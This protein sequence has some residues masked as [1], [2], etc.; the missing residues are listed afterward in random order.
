M[1]LSNSTFFEKLVREQSEKTVITFDT[2]THYLQSDWDKVSRSFSD[3]L[4]YAV[5]QE[6]A[7]HVIGSVHSLQ[8]LIHQLKN[9]GVL[10]QYSDEVKNI[11][12]LHPVLEDHCAAEDQVTSLIQI[13]DASPLCTLS[14]LIDAEHAR[15]TFNRWDRTEIYYRMLV[16]AEGDLFTNQQL[17]SLDQN[18][19]SVNFF[20]HIPAVHH[21]FSG[22]QN[23]DSLK[24]I[25][26]TPGDA[27]QI[28][29]SFHRDRFAP[30]ERTDI[31]L[32][33]LEL[34]EPYPD[35]I[36]ILISSLAAQLSARKSLYL[37]FG[38]MSDYYYL[39]HT[40]S[41]QSVLP[42]SWED[43][44]FLPANSQ[45][46]PDISDYFLKLLNHVESGRY[47][48]ILASLPTKFSKSETGTIAEKMDQA[49][50]DLR[51]LT[52]ESECISLFCTPS[53]ARK[54]LSVYQRT[55]ETM[56]KFPEGTTN[57]LFTNISRRLNS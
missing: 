56:Q 39:T 17:T 16:H 53:T 5:Y 31:E 35:D 44:V 29:R 30:F 26:D 34:F 55:G 10:S 33:S 32:K 23:G 57:E 19:K 11:L 28:Y 14:S 49:F 4:D 27:E 6:K 7:L 51:K 25:S 21:S 3:A 15:D 1:Q 40:S 43:R 2:P 20:G 36:Q 18:S 38:F 8:V 22:I 47:H 42:D 45:T 41:Q 9:Q 48:G 52:E 24:I 12:Q 54:G 13:L 50:M 46:L 37:K